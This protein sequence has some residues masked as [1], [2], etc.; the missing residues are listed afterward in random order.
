[1]TPHSQDQD[2]NGDKSKM[3]LRTLLASGCAAFITVACS[4]TP[5]EPVPVPPP[6]P[7]S[8]GRTTPPPPPPPPAGPTYVINFAAPP[9][10][11]FGRIAFTPTENPEFNA[12]R[13]SFASR[14][15]AQGRSPGAIYALLVDVKAPEP[16]FA[17][18]RSAVDEQAEFADPIWTYVSRRVT[19]SNVSRGQARMA[20]LS[21]FF[22]QME[23]EIG[24]DRSVVASIWGM[25]TSFGGF[26]GTFDAP[27][28]FANLVFERADR[29]AF[30]ESQLLGLLKIMENGEA[31][32][33]QFI[34]SWAGAM[35]QTQFMP[36]TYNAYAIDFDKDGD[37]DVWSSAEDALGSAAN[38]L[39]Q[40]GYQYGEP[41]GIEVTLPAGFDYAV[42]DAQDRR[43]STWKELGLAPIGG[44][45]F[46]VDDSDF[47]ELWL[48]A[49]A[50]GPALLLFRNFDAF[51]TYNRARSYALAVGVWADRLAGKPGLVT[52][53]P[54]HIGQLSK[55][56]VRALQQALTDLGYD[57]RGVDGIIGTNTRKAL[58]AFQKDRGIPADGYPSGAALDAVLAALNAG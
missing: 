8:E 37:K 48:P 57:P 22:D 7:V 4:S 23:T 36:T 35:G 16:T 58:Q 17:V 38:Y 39:K 54:T 26:M 24:V 40:S 42:A 12:W 34:A 43:M 15:E 11:E 46:T 53:W 18:A 49:G 14:A 1:M 20:E 25:E 31:R 28:Q 13:E 32:R 3:T 33:D 2:K 55:A 10:D 47:A 45:E 44:G 6:P 51:M 29:K 41:W 5:A 30:W 19:D 21:T 52:P 27:Q 56:D 9:R 50:Q